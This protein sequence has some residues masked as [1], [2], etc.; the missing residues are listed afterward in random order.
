MLETR[1]TISLLL[2]LLSDE[3]SIDNLASECLLLA[4]VTS[5]TNEYLLLSESDMLREFW[6]ILIYQLIRLLHLMTN[7]NNY[8]TSDRTVLFELN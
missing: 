3:G 5:V 1:T 7:F 6:V 8:K 4:K 2:K